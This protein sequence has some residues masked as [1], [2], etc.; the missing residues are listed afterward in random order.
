MT[1][2]AAF[3]LTYAGFAGLCLGMDR[4]HEEVFRRRL[5]PARQRWLR[6]LGWAALC[7]SFPASVAVWGWLIGPVAWFGLLSA[8]G[9]LLVF[10][11]PYA[12]RACLWLAV[13]CPAASGLILLAGPPA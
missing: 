9:M 4:H 8:A 10:L 6:V 12:P 13:A 2:V 5:T 1:L 3:A 11:L 7:L